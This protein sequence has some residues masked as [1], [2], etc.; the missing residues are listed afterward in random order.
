MRR[1]GKLKEERLKKKFKIARC[2][3]DIKVNSA[4]QVCPSKEEQYQ[5]QRKGYGAK[6]KL[7]LKKGWW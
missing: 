5:T 1:S 3:E 4:H 2:C 6:T 7:Q